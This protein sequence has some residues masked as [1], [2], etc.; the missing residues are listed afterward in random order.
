MGFSSIDDYVNEVTTNGKFWRQDWNKLTAGVA[1]TAG[2]W[3]DLSSLTGTPVANAWAG[4]SLVAQTPHDLNP[5]FGIYTGGDVSTDTKH[6]MNIG[7]YSAVAT[8]V[9]GV[10]MLV[11]MVQYYP[12]I[13]LLTT[14]S[15]QTLINSN[16]F[17]A[18]SSSGLLLTYTNAFGSSGNFTKVRFT[19]SGGA[20]PTGLTAGVDYWLVYVSATTSR[21]ATSLANAIAGTVVAYTDGG[22]GTHTLTV[23]HRY[24]DGAGLRMAMV[25]T[26]LSGTS[27]GT[28]VMTCSYTNQAGTSGRALG[29]TVNFTAGAANIPTPAKIAHSGVAAN[30]YG[31]FLPLAAGDTG[32]QSVQSVTMT[33]NYGGATTVTGALCLYRPLATLPL[34][35]ASVAAERNLMTQLPSLP[36]ILDG[37]CLTWLYFPGAATAASTS[38]FGYVDTA[39][40]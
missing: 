5:G 30:N 3:Y 31:P 19:N 27:S 34:V 1:Y 17:T 14:T 22:S 16:A 12:G 20:L 18:S 6:L 9:P 36:K 35:A 39:W 40:G 13:N 32:V 11:D 4:T 37:A 33:T 21:V 2:N 15:T 26:A 10:L 23:S 24:E 7:A 38:L 28:P 25:S 29:A 8:A